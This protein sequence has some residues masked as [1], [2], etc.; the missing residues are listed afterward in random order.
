M[1]HERAYPMNPDKS[2][3][4]PVDRIMTTVKSFGID[5]VRMAGHATE[6]VL[7]RPW[8]RSIHRAYLDRGL[9]DVVCVFYFE[10]EPAPNLDVP[11]STWILNGE[12]PTMVVPSD[13][14]TGM[15]AVDR[16]LRALEWWS[17]A[18]Y[19]GRSVDDLPHVYYS[20][21]KTRLPPTIKHADYVA[22]RVESMRRLIV[23]WLA[24]WTPE[25]D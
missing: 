16:Y 24:D 4:I 10:Y 12:L 20:M 2:N 7:S 3:L 8:C 9:P 23:P 15:E 6:F 5:Y 18:I 11:S 14:S 25:Q 13:A 19:S 17:E 21:G 1:P 22:E